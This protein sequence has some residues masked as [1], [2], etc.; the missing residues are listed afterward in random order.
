MNKLIQTKK[1]IFLIFPFFLFFLYLPN[2]PIP[3]NF[4]WHDSQR[5]GQILLISYAVIFGVFFRFFEIKNKI[6]FITLIFVSLGILSS[7]LSSHIMWSLTEMSIFLGIYAL[8]IFVYRIFC[9]DYKKLE[10]YSFFALF[11]TAASLFIYF[12]VAYVSSLFIDEEFDV[13][14]FIN[15]FSNPRFFGQFLTLLL[16]VLLAPVLRKSQ[17]SKAFFVLSCAVCFMLIASGT[18]GALLGLGSVMIV[19][20]WL[21][22]LS[23]RWVLLMLKI[24]CA[25]FLMHYFFIE[26][27]PGFLQINVQNSSLDR[28]LLG[29]S[30]RELLW[31]KS[32]SMVIERPFFGFGPMHFANMPN[33]IA[34]HP[35]QLL[36]QILA[37]WGV[38]FFLVFFY[39]SLKLI[40]LIF[41]EL[42]FSEKIKDENSKII[43]VCLS[44]SIFSSLMQSMVDGVFVMPY[45][46]IV[47]VFIA[48]WLAA[49]FY[50]ENKCS[51]IRSLSAQG[52]TLNFL[53]FLSACILLYSFYENSPTYIGKSQENYYKNDGF[54]KP[55]FW[56][57]GGF[58]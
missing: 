46:E 58:K 8:G 39:F 12:F 24:A 11:L 27:L 44:A 2:T 15:G 20:V 7:S 18:R 41:K 57:N 26:I 23:R 32:I 54:L 50:K 28:K 10:I 51:P 55:R 40:F 45:T 37:E 36:L 21:S 13:W 35:H 3:I 17:W 56:I 52:W 25:A 1:E 9:I 49:V 29:L 14:Q 19:Y 30:A 53:F 6:F 47:F 38:L 16:P 22:N 33:V 34:N 4:H 5:I 48:A 43:Y 31:G 42:I